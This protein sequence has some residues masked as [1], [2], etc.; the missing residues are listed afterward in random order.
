MPLPTHPGLPSIYKLT[1]I[2]EVTKRMFIG[3]AMAIIMVAQMAD[4]VNAW[5]GLKT[6][7]YG[8]EWKQK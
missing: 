7:D 4:S 3:I 1:Q 2:W 6:L 5:K 8:K